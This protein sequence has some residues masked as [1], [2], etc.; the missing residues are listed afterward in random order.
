MKSIVNTRFIAR[1]AIIAALYAGL[2]IGLAP[3][4]YMAIQFRLSEILTL[5]VFVNPIFAPG[6]VLGTVI[7]NLF[8][9]LGM[10]DVIFGTIATILSVRYMI[11]SKNIW[12]ASLF[13]TIFNGI[14]IGAELHFVYALPLVLTMLQVAVGEFVV[15]TV[16]GVP[17]VKLLL[18]NKAFMESIEN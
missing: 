3:I 17:L 12:M 8:S 11:I 16:I 13:P 14:I 9:P 6:L 7:A 15:V 18:K 4:S 5:L 2:T 10:I 1:T